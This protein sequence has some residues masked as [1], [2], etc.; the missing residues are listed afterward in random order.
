MTS[1]DDYISRI[2]KV[3]DEGSALLARM[4][5]P[6]LRFSDFV[7][8]V[9]QGMNGLA[10]LRFP[11][12][13][14]VVVHSAA[15]RSD[16]D[17]VDAH[18]ASL[19]DRLVEQAKVIGA[20][21]VGFANVIDSRSGDVV[22]L[23]EV[24]N[25]LVERADK[26]GLAILNGENAILGSRVREVNVSGTMI[27]IVK[28]SEKLPRVHRGLFVA[29][30]NVYS[31]F[32]HEGKAISINSDGV[33]T[34]T[35]FYERANLF[36]RA[37]Y[38]F[39]AMNL[40]DAVK[41]ACRP[42][43]VSGVLETRG[44]VPVRLIQD[45]IV[46]AG[47]TLDIACSLQHE[48]VNGR[49]CSYRSDVPAFN[50]GG[51]VVSTVDERWLESPPVAREGDVLVAVRGRSNPRSNGITSRREMMAK[52]FGENWHKR[53]ECMAFLDYLCEPSTVLY[54]FF[55]HV[56]DKGL[57]NGVYHLSGGAYDGK[58]ARPLAKLGLFVRLTDIFAPN[59]CDMFFVDRRLASSNYAANNISTEAL[60]SAF[61][62]YSMGTD[63]F[64]ATN[65]HHGV[66]ESA[67]KC[68]LDA[69]VVGRLERSDR[70]GVEI[71]FAQKKI[72]FSGRD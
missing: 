7:D 57:A 39:L 46:N 32:D 30:G 65:N 23:S 42:R 11:E 43:V 61:A 22:L 48:A 8:V 55:A 35:E 14:K 59:K 45:E 9:E 68:G 10:V 51:S 31:I 15:G 28:A 50:I 69:K 26:Y 19:V 2:V 47:Q 16:E 20:M 62:K 18:S 67:R 36:E 66:V 3:G 41:R 5:A 64:V 24:A 70:T 12:N 27:S 58:L 29:E 13:V 54:P 60:T 63:G 72:Y 52:V 71:Q 49:L 25:A 4:C 53:E 56:L 33:G 17:D 38:D 34:K 6:S 44:S 1:K 37:V 21:P 40:D